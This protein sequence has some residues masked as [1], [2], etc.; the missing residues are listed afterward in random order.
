MVGAYFLDPSSAQADAHL[1][2][3]YC[4]L[5]VSTPYLLYASLAAPAGIAVI[6]AFISFILCCMKPART[7]PKPPKQ[8]K[9]K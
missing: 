6:A 2:A 4:T 7:T 3:D 9:G 8:P 5:T 1:N